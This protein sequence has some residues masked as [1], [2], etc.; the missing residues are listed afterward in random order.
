MLIKKFPGDFIVEEIPLGF[1]G[2]GEYAIYR[3]TKKEY[4]T[5]SAVQYIC[6]KFNIPR[7]NIK[8][9]G[10]KDKHAVTKQY[11][12]IFKDKGH[13]NID[14]E[15]IKL[16]FIS[17]HDE[18]L[19]LGSLHGNTFNIKIRELAPEE[20]RTFQMRFRQDFI[21]PNYFDDQRF[22]EN[23]YEIGLAILKRDFKK[24]CEL[25]EIPILGNDYVTA[26]KKIPSK[27][28]LFYVHA[29]QSYLFNRELSEKIMEMGEYYLREYRHGQLA[30]LEDKNYDRDG[31]KQL[32]LAGFD[33]DNRLL[34]EIG[35]T[36]RDFI[37]KQFPELTVEGVDRECFVETNVFYKINKNEII[38][39]N[40][41][42][43]EFSLPKGC[44]ATM[45]IKAL[46]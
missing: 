14:A 41:I 42:D 12:S 46:F 5:E 20:L 30:F 21:F 16:E 36:S 1:S 38:D 31:C 37:I 7:S 45:L 6:K 10:S 33:S 28:L 43:L 11:I 22:S 24:A 32:K 23:N 8:Y 9:G 18:P 2:N 29:V 19:S 17:L 25:L 13:L 44:Y 15:D 39:N 4:N 26:L 34:S 35:L 27:T 3:L 40:E